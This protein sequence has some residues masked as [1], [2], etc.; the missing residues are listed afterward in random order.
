MKTYRPTTASRRH[1][2]VVHY[3][4]VS[5]RTRPAKHLTERLTKHAGRNA[6]GRITMRHQGGGNLILYRAVDFKQQKF[7][8]QGRVESVEYD[9]YRTAFI[10]LVVY[11]DG[12]RRYVL[13]PNGLSVGA[14]IV[15]AV[16]APLLP[17]NRTALNR[18]PVGTFVHNIELTAGRGGQ[19]ARAA[20]TSVQVLAQENSYTHLKMPSGEVRKIHGMCYATIGQVSNTEYN[21]TTLGKAG[22]SRWLNIRPT[23]R[24]KVMNPRDHPYGGGEGRTQRGTR[25]PKTKWGK[26][27]GG[28]KTRSK[29]KWSSTLIVKRRS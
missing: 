7:G 1:S 18:I 21:L 16:D 12:D 6:Q 22:R 26:I 13:A 17:G 25:R 20:G 14:T 2:T 28:R 23:V 5:R 27:T 15:T 3:N 10:A 9:P 19:F 24:G 4:A 8:V 11:A 29:K